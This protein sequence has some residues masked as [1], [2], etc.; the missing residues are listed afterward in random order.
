MNGSIFLAI[1]E[2]FGDLWYVYDI[3]L[4]LIFAA[5][6]V[7]IRLLKKRTKGRITC[8]LLN[9][10]VKNLQK[11]ELVPDMAR[12]KLYLLT[13]LNLLKSADY[14]YAVHVEEH[15]AYD[16]LD[17]RYALK[18]MIIK[19]EEDTDAGIAETKVK[20][21]EYLNI[22]KGIKKPVVKGK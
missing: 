8:N 4:V 15:D 18:E 7:L 2:F 13:A 5:C 17:S 1:P 16:F 10:A 12:T 9:S 21:A 11:A 22:I 19:M 3:L 14:Y 20:I 6:L